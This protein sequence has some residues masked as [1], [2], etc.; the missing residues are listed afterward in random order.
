M[1]YDVEKSTTTTKSNK[2]LTTKF[3]FQSIDNKHINILCIL[4]KSYKTLGW[5][6]CDGTYLFMY[7]NKLQEELMV[8][9]MKCIKSFFIFNIKHLTFG[10][11]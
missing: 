10:I 3:P 8:Y 2:L 11:K 5:L 7:S 1:L 6:N 9:F 4:K